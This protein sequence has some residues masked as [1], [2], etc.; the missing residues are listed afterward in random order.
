MV[1]A[2]LGRMKI[3]SRLGAINRTVQLYKLGGCGMGTTRRDFLVQG[4]GLFGGAVLTARFGGMVSAGT[5]IRVGACDTS[6]RVK[7]DPGSL[8]V[9]KRIGLDGVEVFAGNAEDTLQVAKPDYRAELK[10]AMAETGVPVASIMMGLLNGS[11]LATDPRG[12]A[13]LEQ[14]VY[15]ASDLGAEVIL[16]AFFGKGDLRDGDGLKMK[17]VDAAVERIREAAP[18]A[19]KKGVTLGIENTLSGRDNMMILDRIQHDSVKVYYDVGNSTGNG[20]DVPA[21]IRMMKDSI[22]QIHFKDRKSAYLG[23]GE[24]AY[25]P[26]AEAMGAIDYGGWVMLETKVAGDR[27]GDFAKNAAFT[28]ELLGIG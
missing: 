17:E 12:P 28:R 6:M 21:E 18:L 19:A 4:A 25:G 9:A 5:K 3:G 22:C 24:V 16:V 10:A 15:A 1:A 11:P 14:T 7:L 13:W 8:A 23:Q 27:D 2:P 26:V 20:Y